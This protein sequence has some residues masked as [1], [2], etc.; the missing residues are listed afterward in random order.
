MDINFSFKMSNSW[1]TD[2]YLINALTSSFSCV[3]LKTFCCKNNMEPETKN[4]IET[5]IKNIPMQVNVPT[6][7]IGPPVDYDYISPVYLDQELPTKREN[8]KMQSN[9]DSEIYPS[10][11][12]EQLDREI[13]SYQQDRGQFLLYKETIKNIKEQLKIHKDMDAEKKKNRIARFGLLTDTDHC[14]IM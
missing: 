13:D 1:I 6:V 5:E 12:A 11:S 14:P 9:D 8:D 10:V 4:N 2:N 7:C 3:N